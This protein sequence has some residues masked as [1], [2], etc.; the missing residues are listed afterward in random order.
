MAEGDFLLVSIILDNHQFAL[1][2]SVLSGL[3]MFGRAKKV[4]LEEEEK[5]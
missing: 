3:G 4:D 2:P 1:L 5:P